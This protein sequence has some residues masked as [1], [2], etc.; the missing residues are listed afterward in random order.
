[1]VTIMTATAAFILFASGYFA[2]RLRGMRTVRPF[3][4]LRAALAPRQ[5]D[6]GVFPLGGMCMALVG[7]LG[8]GNIAGVSTALWLGGLGAIIW[9]IF[10]GLAVAVLKYAEIVLAIRHRRQTGSGTVGGHC[11]PAFSVPHWF[12]VL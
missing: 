3:R 10:S 12:W 2:V 6:T 11:S 7:T 5:T 8:V 1:M 9:M 4:R